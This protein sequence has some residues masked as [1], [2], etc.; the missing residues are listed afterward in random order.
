ML[1]SILSPTTQRVRLHTKEKINK[2]IQKKTQKNI[3]YYKTRSRKEIIAR[4]ENLDK[5]W[6]IERALETNAAIIILLSVFLGIITN[7]IGWIILIG[8]ISGFLLQHA[9]QG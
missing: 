3:E 8:I 5:E 9:L 2:R 4:I 1:K 6:D 7:K